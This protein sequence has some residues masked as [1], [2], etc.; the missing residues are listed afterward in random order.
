MPNYPQKITFGEM[1]ETGKRGLLV[2]CRDYKCNH[3]IKIPPAE[4]DKWPD[5]LR[6]SD[7]EPRFVCTV[8]GQRGA[9]I[10]GDT[11]SPKMGLLWHASR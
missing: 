11:S 1:R 5:D 4:A 6:I 8:C 3:F 7:L 10:R 9:M 2:Y